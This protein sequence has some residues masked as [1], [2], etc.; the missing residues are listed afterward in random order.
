MADDQTA[1]LKKALAKFELFMWLTDDELE[2]VAALSREET[3]AAGISIIAEGATAHDLYMVEEGQ[4]RVEMSLSVYPGLVQDS[5]VEIIPKGEPFGWSAVIGSRVYTMTA[6]AMEQV[7]V[8]AIDGEKLLALFNKNPDIGFK[9]ME[10]LV[11][12]VSQ[13]VRSVK[14]TLLV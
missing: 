1:S 5:L 14:K 13:R 3:F 7:K 11:S 4:V 9:V 2:K 12:V 10:G 8:I 6:R